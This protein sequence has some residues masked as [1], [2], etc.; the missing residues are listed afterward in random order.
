MQGIFKTNPTLNKNRKHEVFNFK[1]IMS[2][3]GGHTSEIL[4]LLSAMSVTYAP[5]EYVVANTD[6]M[7][8]D[9]IRSAE[10]TKK[11]NESPK[12]RN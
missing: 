11:S 5:R 2:F 6:K 10:S 3:P 9:K 1:M 7:S 8:E 12:V 4:R